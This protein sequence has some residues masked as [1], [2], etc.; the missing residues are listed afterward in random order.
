MR[1]HREAKRQPISPHQ[2]AAVAL[3]FGG[4][5]VATRRSSNVPTLVCAHFAHRA[6]AAARALHMRTYTAQRT[7]PMACRTCPTDLPRHVANQVLSDLFVY[8]WHF[9]DEYKTA[10]LLDVTHTTHWNEVYSPLPDSIAA[11]QVD[12]AGTLAGYASCTMEEV[13]GPDAFFE[14]GSYHARHHDYYEADNHSTKSTTFDTT[15]L[16]LL[17]IPPSTPHVSHQRKQGHYTIHNSHT[18]TMPYTPAQADIAN[19]HIAMCPDYPLFANGSGND[20]FISSTSGSYRHYTSTGSATFSAVA[21]TWEADMDMESGE[22]SSSGDNASMAPPFVV[23]LPSILALDDAG[24]DTSGSHRSHTGPP[25]ALFDD[26]YDTF[27]SSDDSLVDQNQPSPNDV[28]GHDH[29]HD[30]DH[31]NHHHHRVDDHHNSSP[32]DSQ[33]NTCDA[34][35]PSSLHHTSPKHRM[36]TRTGSQ[37]PGT[38]R[39]CSQQVDYTTDSTRA[40]SALSS[41]SSRGH[42][43]YITLKVKDFNNA[44]KDRGLSEDLIKAM[45]KNRRRE[46]NRRYSKQGRDRKRVK[47]SVLKKGSRP[48]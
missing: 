4:G 42:L 37:R 47:T 15:H 45:R 34:A 1:T 36:R 3:F 18:S 43:W 35:I 11:S 14:Q 22:S 33:D 48:Q 39:A 29:D 38:M 17:P 40:D 10:L 23:A 41:P 30:H 20:N 27:S 25:K 2:R 5:E 24:Y 44:C 6:R 26:G 21:T 28:D 32:A 16:E 8:F 9:P 31:G 12:L 19:L 7:H 13:V 46:K